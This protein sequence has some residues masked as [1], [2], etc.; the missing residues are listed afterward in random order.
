MFA[1]VIPLTDDQAEY[2]TQIGA[3]ARLCL[4][5]KEIAEGLITL[6]CQSCNVIQS[7]EPKQG[8]F[9]YSV[10]TVNPF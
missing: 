2:R 10:A 6:R 4:Y 9:T 1:H 5:R 3:T 7:K 8:F